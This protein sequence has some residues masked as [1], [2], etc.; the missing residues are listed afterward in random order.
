MVIYQCSYLI[1]RSFLQSDTQRESASAITQSSKEGCAFDWALKFI[2]PAQSQQKYGVK[3]IGMY[4]AGQFYLQCMLT[5]TPERGRFI[6]H[7]QQI[8]MFT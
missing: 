2:T 7:A 4:S 8:I 6:A 3:I 5:I 1:L